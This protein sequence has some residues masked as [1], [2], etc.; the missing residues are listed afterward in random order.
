ME[1]DNAHHRRRHAGPCHQSTKTLFL[2]VLCFF[3]CLFELE[4]DNAH[5]RRHAGPCHQS[6]KNVA[7]VFVSFYVPLFVYLSWRIIVAMQAMPSKY[8]NTNCCRCFCLFLCLFE[9]E[10]DNAHHRRHAGHAIKV[11]KIRKVNGK[12][13][14]RS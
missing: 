14:T 6:T 11:Q 2:F 9:F 13:M 12:T 7:I 5:H 4:E 3:I 1:E 10:E 8:K